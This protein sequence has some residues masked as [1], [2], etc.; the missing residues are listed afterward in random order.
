MKAY[1]IADRRHPLLD[2]FG[3]YL[4]GGRWNSPGRRI[5]YA[6][7]S[8]AVA[9]LE[10][11]VHLPFGAV[12]ASH[13]WIEITLPAPASLNGQ[14][15]VERLDEAALPG[16]A[17]LDCRISRDFGDVWQQSQRSLVLDVPSLA[18]EGDRNLLINQDHPAFAGVTASA[19]HPLAWDERLFRR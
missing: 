1:R 9:R 14:T 17:A 5:I 8:L 13:A 15:L 4:H 18:A 10:L 3:A 2:G 11:L 7:A 19:A 12:P 16:W 6:A